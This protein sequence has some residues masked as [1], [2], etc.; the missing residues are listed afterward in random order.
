[1]YHVIIQQNI[2]F[3]VYS[4]V[5]LSQPE[6]KRKKLEHNNDDKVEDIAGNV[7]KTNCN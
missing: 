1:M 3:I 4:I 2:Y 7:T 6:R 5:F